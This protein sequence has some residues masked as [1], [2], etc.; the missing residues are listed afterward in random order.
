MCVYV[1]VCVSTIS[2]AKKLWII[3]ITLWPF[4]KVESK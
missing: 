1:C 2:V 4:P 3:L